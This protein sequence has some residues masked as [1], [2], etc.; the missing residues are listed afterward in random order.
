MRLYGHRI[1]EH[2][3]GATVVVDVDDGDAAA[4]RRAT[5]SRRTPVVM[6]EADTGGFRHVGERAG[7]IATGEGACAQGASN[8]VID[9]HRRRT[10]P[11]GPPDD[12][13]HDGSA[14]EYPQRAPNTSAIR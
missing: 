12:R 8:T 7:G 5:A 2:E 11:Q 1:D 9:A 14:S 10:G 3:I 6:D 13:A 4:H